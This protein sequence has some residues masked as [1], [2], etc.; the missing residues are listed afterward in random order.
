VGLKVKSGESVI[1]NVDWSFLNKRSC[2][3]KPLAL[4]AGNIGTALTY[5][6]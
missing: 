4:S 1:K 2:N 3:G 6:R 5:G